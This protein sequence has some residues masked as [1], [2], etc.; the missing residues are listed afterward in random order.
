MPNYHVIVHGTE[1]EALA[2]LGRAHQ[3]WLLGS[4]PYA[5]GTAALYTDHTQR[6][7]PHLSR[8]DKATGMNHDEYVRRYLPFAISDGLVRNSDRS[9]PFLDSYIALP[10][11]YPR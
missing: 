3:P 10:A 6:A 2:D 5:G 9:P 4:Y 1:R 8:A 7:A 11:A